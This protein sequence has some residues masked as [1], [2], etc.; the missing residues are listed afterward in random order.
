MLSGKRTSND[1]AEIHQQNKNVLVSHRKRPLWAETVEQVFKVWYR[2]NF[3]FI[4]TKMKFFSNYHASQL[5][6]AIS[7]SRAMANLAAQT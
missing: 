6:N 3:L 1:T 5:M 2:T 7:K 4:V